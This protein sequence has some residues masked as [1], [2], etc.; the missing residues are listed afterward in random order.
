MGLSTSLPRPLVK[1]RICR[2]LGEA[3]PLRCGSHVR[4]APRKR[5]FAAHWRVSAKCPTGDI[6]N[7]R[8]RQLRRPY[9][10]PSQTGRGNPLIDTDCRIK[11]A[12]LPQNGVTFEAWLQFCRQ[13]LKTFLL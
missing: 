13:S 1:S 5:T 11:L 2:G 9:S 10:L 6:R 4:F 12:D 3:I 7:E 8:G